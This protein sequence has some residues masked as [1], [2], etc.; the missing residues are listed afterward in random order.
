MWGW[1]CCWQCGPLVWLRGVWGD[2]ALI[3]LCWRLGP[4]GW[5]LP[6]LCGTGSVGA[7]HQN[8]SR[9]HHWSPTSVLSRYFCLQLCRSQGVRLVYPCNWT[10]CGS[11]TMLIFRGR[12]LIAGEG[13]GLVQFEGVRGTINSLENM[14]QHLRVWQESVP[15]TCKWHVQ[16][17]CF[18][19]SWEV[20]IDN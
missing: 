12:R 2:D 20:L 10:R 13:W 9:L 8:S 15:W 1:S 7:L 6:Q 4:L 3:W 14:E 19:A 11:T 16:L 5:V 17:R 18:S